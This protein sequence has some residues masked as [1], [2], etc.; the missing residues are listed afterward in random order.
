MPTAKAR[1]LAQAVDL[2]SDDIEKGLGPA[3]QATRGFAVPETAKSLPVITD[4]HYTVVSWEYRAKH[5]GEFQGIVAT[6]NNVVIRGI[7]IVDHEATGG[8]LYHRHVDW[9][10]LMA[11]I[12]LTTTQRPAVAKLPKPAE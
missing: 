4:G 7:T 1:L 11:Q 10:D 2:V 5:T 3:F 8:P 9:L 6:Y 12:G